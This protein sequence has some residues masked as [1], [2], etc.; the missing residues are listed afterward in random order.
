MPNLPVGTVTFLFTDIEGST[1]LWEAHPEAMQA[2]LARH[3]A[4]LR[5]AIEAHSGHVFKTVGDAFCAAFINARQAVCA[6]ARIQEQLTSLQ[7][8]ELPLNV[9]IA[10]HT[11]VAEVRDRDYFGPPLNRVARLLA[12]GHGGQ[13]LLSGATQGLVRHD[14]PLH[15]ALRDLRIHHLRDLGSPEHVFQLLHPDLREDFPRLRSLDGLPNNLPHQLTSFVE[16]KTEMAEAR[17]LLDCS[18]LLTLTG[19]GGTGKTRL[20]VQLAAEVLDDYPDGVWIV[21]LAPL[22]DAE[23]VTQ[24]VAE[25]LGVRKGAGRE[26]A[27]ALR[28]KRLLILLDNCEHLLTSVANLVEILMRACPHVRVLATSREALGVAGEQ[29]YRVPCLSL[30]GAEDQPYEI[31]IEFEAIRLFLERGLL[32]DP[33]F[34]MTASTAPSIVRIC[35]RLD[36]IP[37]AIELAAARLG[38]LPVEKL[39]ERLEHSFRI[40]TGGSR[41]ALPQHRTLQALIGWSY[42]LLTDAEKVLLRRLAVFSGGWTVETAEVVGRGGIIEE[43]EVLNLLLRLVEKN[44]VFSSPVTPRY[45]LLETVREF[46]WAQAI[47]S[48]EGEELRNRHRD[49]FLQLA[50]QAEPY[51]IGLDQTVWHDRLEREKDNLRSA[52]EWSSQQAE[53]SDAELRLSGA[54]WRFWGTRGYL[55]E[56]RDHL[57]RALSR[58]ANPATRAKAL[59]AAGMLARLQGDYH[60]ADLVLKESL[61]I[62][63]TL[64]RQRERA[65]ALNNLGLMAQ[66]QNEFQA[67]RALHEESLEIRRALKDHW[68]TGAS[69]NNLACVAQDEGNLE[70]AK[71][72]YSEALDAIRLGGSREIEGMI[73]TNLAEVAILLGRYAEARLLVAEGTK[74]QR[75]LWDLMGLIHCLQ[76]RA[77]LALREDDVTLA[78]QLYGAVEKI[79]ETTGATL[80]PHER[81][82]QLANIAAARQALGSAAFSVA[83]AAGHSQPLE[84]TIEL[85]LEKADA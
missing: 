43:E 66:E 53:G 76:T 8:T 37:L 1:K 22:V 68:G 33:H 78:T 34:Q 17:S 31:L 13:V 10:L 82:L 14:L 5:E 56:G 79:R 62:W 44:L 67:A 28:E 64:G 4:L 48:I 16:R 18:R 12:I 24:T 51:L 38:A 75:E 54:L 45:H 70:D 35:R 20:S 27:E 58:T 39:A 52:L 65:A 41:R 6:A 80:A 85:A 3:D 83:W 21:E 81:E 73:L 72:L 32:A 59:N 15:F 9:R 61:A 49:H 46:A 23:L 36:G 57:A 42:D 55:T 84:R 7:T 30:P 11:G 19:A 69:L 71:T 2:A 50:E 74:I 60:E 63:S 77:T 47:L 29:A 25:T 26:I 40:L